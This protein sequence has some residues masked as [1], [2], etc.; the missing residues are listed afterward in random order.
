MNL[1]L[2]IV[3]LP[4]VGKSTLFNALTAL[5][6]QAENYPF[7]TIEP[8]VGIVAVNDKRL[9]KLAEIEKSQNIINAVVKFVDIAGLVKG[10]SKGEG[11]GNK[12]LSNIRETDAIVHVLRRFKDDNV[13][14]VD[15][16]IDV[17]RDIQTIETELI[18]KD[19][20]VL[21]KKIKTIEKD[22][23]FDQKSKTIFEYLEGLNSHLGRGLLAI[24]YPLHKEEFVNKERKEMYLLSDKPILYL[25]NESQDKINSELTKQLQKEIDPSEKHKVIML[26]V[27]L[28]HEISLLKGDEKS[29]FLTE[30]GLDSSPID[31]LITASYDILGLH[32]FFTAGEKEARAWTIYKGDPITKAAGAIHTD[33][34]EKFIAADVVAYEDFVNVGGWQKAKELGKIRLEG[35]SYIVKDGDVVI[36][37]HGA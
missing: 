3:G 25:I 36:I 11:L 7:C 20:E 13:T 27:K 17:M 26:D 15:K 32:S 28:E 12:F 9:D 2:G 33:F 6:V 18:I 19:T 30:L 14:H 37:R 4:N 29:E 10:A 23:R 16:S 22:I 35:K 1:S 34:E 24:D 31:K 8:N 5:Q 21:E